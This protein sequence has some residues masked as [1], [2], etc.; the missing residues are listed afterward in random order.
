MWVTCWKFCNWVCVG[1]TLV[2]VWTWRFAVILKF[3]RG[4]SWGNSDYI[5]VE[6]DDL[7]LGLT[8]QQFIKR[9]KTSDFQK[10]SH[11]REGAT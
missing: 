5:T 1:M 11:L 6:C 8:S 10:T 4:K 3:Y 9:L 2:M 7:Y